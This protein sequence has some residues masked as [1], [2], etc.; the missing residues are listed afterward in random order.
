MMKTTPGVV[1]A[2]VTALVAGYAAVWGQYYVSA[3]YPG[4]VHEIAI[5]PLQVSCRSVGQDS[6]DCLSAYS[7]PVSVFSESA[8]VISF[9]IVLPEYRI[10]CDRKGGASVSR[11]QVLE[12]RNS[13]VTFNQGV[14]GCS[15]TVDLTIWRANYY[16]VQGLLG[17]N[18][19]VATPRAAQAYESLVVFFYSTLRIVLLVLFAFALAINAVCGR[20]D[21]PGTRTSIS[22]RFLVPWAAFLL[23][24][25]GVLATL[26]GGRIPS[27]HYL[28]LNSALSSMAHLGPILCSLLLYRVR[29]KSVIWFVM[30]IC[31]IAPSVV[32]DW[33]YFYPRIGLAASV[34]ALLTVFGGFGRA[35]GLTL[36]FAA[37]YAVNLLKLSGFVG[38]F[39]ALLPHVHVSSVFLGVALFLRSLGKVQLIGD[40]MAAE[41]SVEREPP[42]G[43][44]A[45]FLAAGLKSVHGLIF[46]H[47][48]KV[49]FHRPGAA[50]VGVISVHPS[51]AQELKE[52]TNGEIPAEVV[53]LLVIGSASAWKVALREHLRRSSGSFVVRFAL[54]QQGLYSAVVLIHLDRI[55]VDANALGD[56]FNR[57]EGYQRVL[58]RVFGKYSM[59]LQ[60]ERAELKMQLQTVCRNS[61]NIDELWNYGV[62]FLGKLQLRSF[63][64]EVERAS[65]KLR[66]LKTIGYAAEVGEFLKRLQFNAV[67]LGESKGPVPIAVTEQRTVVIDDAEVLKPHLTEYSRELLSWS[68]ARSL[69]VI[70]KTVM[71]ASS[72]DKF[73]VYFESSEVARF[74][75]EV[76]SLLTAFTDAF[77]E[78]LVEMR[79]Q[80]SA[81]ETNKILE[82]AIPTR[83]LESIRQG[84][85]VREERV[86]F[87][88]CAD[89]RGSTKLYRALGST[90]F[91]ALIARISERLVEC[92]AG[93]PTTELDVVTW[94][95]FFISAEKNL[96]SERFL[97]LAI[98]VGRTC[99][100]I[101]RELGSR[102]Q[103]LDL[104][105]RV[106]IT[107]GDVTRDLS[108]GINSSWTIVGGAMAVVCKFEAKVKSQGSGVFVDPAVATEFRPFARFLEG[109]AALQ[110]ADLDGEW[111]PSR[112]RSAA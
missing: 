79:S 103:E 30:V 37:I 4:H 78:A 42:G 67:D 104:G 57:L 106:C 52:C 47:E 17:G 77:V 70:P 9:G 29:K 48:L 38:E 88:L 34:A 86:G 46:P 32:P 27:A 83:V 91:T 20:L 71:S 53:R 22:E 90:E 45:R 69:A 97:E 95:A 96:S 112:S 99:D 66:V 49:Y 58:A 63:I 8:T 100:Q 56:L 87:L 74:G 59:C 40:I 62:E 75:A 81:R 102:Y 61:S 28:L 24:S 107:V 19:F 23:T 43:N 25:S 44:S 82:R 93:F 110:L 26:L 3:L 111:R 55:P 36:G 80:L 94:D 51:G 72:S 76:V 11:G 65:G 6:P 54:S 35:D 92:C 10:T 64:G 18:T 101:L 73:V 16:P 50:A 21:L 60:N 108:M 68:A 15:E 5:A 39:G 14:L 1:A 33:L 84:R 109:S 31:G 89:I 98:A 13:P 2:L 105:V 85:P 12:N 7:V 41:S